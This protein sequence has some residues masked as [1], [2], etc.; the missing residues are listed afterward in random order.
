MSR[1]GIDYYGVGYYG[2]G[3]AT[4]YDA[5]PFTATP[6]GYG[7]IRL[8]WVTPTGSW[9]KIRI[10]RNKYG[11]PVDAWDGQV[12]VSAYNGAIDDNHPDDYNI[13]QGYYYYY[14]IFVL[15]TVQ[16]TW[17]RAANTYAVAVKHYGNGE[18]MYSYLP[19]IYKITEPYV[20]TSDSENDQL[21]RFLKIFGFELDYVQTITA[22][23]TARYNTETVNGIL[24]PKLMTQ[25]GLVYEPEIGIQQ[26]RILLRDG[27][28]INKEKGT[29]QGLKEFI[30]STTGYGI[31]EPIQSTPNPSVEGVKVS[32]NIML[33]YNDSSFE[34]GY[35][36]WV[37]TDGTALIDW[38][39]VL[40]IQSVSL[41]SNTARVVIGPNNYDVGND[42]VISGLSLPLFNNITP[43]T[44]TGVD[45]TS[46]IEFSL[47]G[48]DILS[49]SGFNQSTGEYGL[50]TPS[51][52]PWVEPTAPSLY[53]NKT[54]GIVA[55]YNSYAASQTI[56]IFCGDDEPITKGIPVS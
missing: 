38:L 10:V 32:H 29:L 26:N 27:V 11:Y 35:G 19:Q 54:S 4:Q 14:S 12:I 18:K 37:S 16:Y 36:H 51:P 33:D 20:A 24:I 3:I 25:F 41:T 47:T 46:Y 13:E 56:N 45:Q 17:V 8:K 6:Y 49:T 53:P 21:L 55:F 40:P 23:L 48:T 7:T 42:V 22:L 43:V 9:A 31:P 15:E 34:E 50:V 2:A 39:S 1:Y 28:S 52:A 30:K 44:I 5:Y